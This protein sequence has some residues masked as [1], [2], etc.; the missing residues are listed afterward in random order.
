M[1]DTE[2]V[3]HQQIWNSFTN[4]VKFGTGAV[5]LVVVLLWFFL[6]V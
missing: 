1:A 2:L 3:R 6:V 5:L 4:F